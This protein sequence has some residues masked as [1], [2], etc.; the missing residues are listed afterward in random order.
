MLLGACQPAAQPTPETIIQ[1]VV[2]EG[3]PQ[4]IVVTA[5]PAPVEPA[6]PEVPALKTLN[7]NLG[8]GDVPTLDPAV[9]EDTSSIQVSESIYGGVTRLNEEKVTIEPN[10]AKSWDISEDGKTYT[11]HLRD[12]VYWVKYDA[13]QGAVVQVMGCGDTPQPRKV[14]AKDF[15]YGFLRT[16]KPATASPYAYVS[17]FVIQGA[18][19]Y[20]NGKTEDATTVGVKAVDDTT[21]EIKFLDAAAYNVNIAGMWIGYAQPSWLIDGDDCTEARGERWIE[22]GFNQSYGPFT[23]KEWVHDSDLVVVKNPFWPAGVENTPQPKIDQITFTMLDSTADFSEYEAGQK[24][25]LHETPLADMDRIK[26]DPVLS[27]ELHIAPSLATYYYGF[28]ITAPVVDD[29]R[30]R[31]ALSLAVDR[32]SLI[33]N[34]TKANQEPAGW[35]CRPGLVGCPQPA[36]YKYPDLGVAFDAAKAKEILQGYLDEKKLTADQLDLTLMFN[37]SSGH[38]KIAEAIQQMWKDN[39]GLN[40]K[41]VNQEWKV[42]LVT[43]KSKDTPQI[44]RMGWSVDYPDANNWDREVCAAGGSQN[45]TDAAGAPAGGFMWKNDKYEEL[46]KQAATELDP[47]K[48]IQLYAQAEQILVWDDAVMIPLY[49]YTSAQ[50]TKPYVTRTYSPTGHEAFEKWDVDMAAKVAAGGQ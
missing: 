1:T 21:L 22:A 40:V 31:R 3:Q 47:A 29:V 43:T 49:W 11:F 15:E 23:L 8:V 33:D 41:L 7:W 19:D 25:A 2:V 4:T 35:F 18:A 12:D 20:N 5:T 44:F 24:D 50:L 39:L 42:Y 6:A 38:Q 32:Q 26:A 46:V 36:D 48:R 14:T 45:P 30:V 16:L 37:T 9:A 10:L 28:N 17:A 27:K 13:K 34:V